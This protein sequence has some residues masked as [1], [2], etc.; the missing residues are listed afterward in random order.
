MAT[1]QQSTIDNQRTLLLP[2][3]QAA[4]MPAPQKSK[5]SS[6]IELDSPIGDI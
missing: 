2:L 3:M 1:L 6:R 5:Q 4:A